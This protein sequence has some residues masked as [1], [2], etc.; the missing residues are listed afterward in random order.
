M[1]GSKLRQRA[2]TER[3]ARNRVVHRVL[4]GLNVQPS[5]GGRLEPHLALATQVVQRPAGPKIWGRGH[6]DSDDAHDDC[7][8]LKWIHAKYVTTV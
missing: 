4:G 1:R 7:D 5:F 6:D 3:T 2:R 8:D